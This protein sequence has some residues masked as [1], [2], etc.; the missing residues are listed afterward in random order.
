M[1][2]LPTMRLLR[3]WYVRPLFY[4]T[5]SLTYDW[6][7]YVVAYI[8]HGGNVFFLLV[9][10]FLSR[11]TFPWSHLLVLLAYLLAYL[12]FV[13]LYRAIT[14]NYVYPTQN[15]N[16]SGVAAYLIYPVMVILP[17]LLLLP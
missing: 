10:V 17:I 2:F 5:A 15:S 11:I 7:G 8:A 12:V 13:L 1:V 6:L 3:A 9:E 4:S 14:G 16:K